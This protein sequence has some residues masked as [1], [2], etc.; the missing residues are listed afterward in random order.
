MRSR[1]TKRVFSIKKKEAL[2]ILNSTNLYRKE[3]MIYQFNAEELFQKVFSVAKRQVDLNLSTLMA[4]KVSLN[5]N[6]RILR[7]T[8]QTSPESRAPCTMQS[9][10][11]KLP[12][13]TA[14]KLLSLVM[15]L[16][17]DIE[18]AAD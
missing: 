18:C 16:R 2:Y 14:N 6:R 15:N 5:P 9:A 3:R 4:L 12:L 7:A 17:M 1:K 11:Y 8:S 13:R 10:L